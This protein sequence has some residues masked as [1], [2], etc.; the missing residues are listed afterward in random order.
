M[1][2]TDF[3]LIRPRYE[4]H[5]ESLLE[6]TADMHAAVGTTS[7]GLKEKLIAL[8]TGQDKIKK[9]GFQIPDPMQNSSRVVPK[10]LT[11][12]M[13]FYEE[14]I[15]NLF[16]NFYPAHC[17]LPEQFIH[18]TCTGY[19]FPSPAQK[20]ISKRG[21][22]Q[23]FVT[24]VYHMGC[25]A[26]IP[27]MRIAAGSLATEVSTVDIIHTEMCSLHFHPFK[28]T[29]EQLIIQSLF[30]DGFIKYSLQ[31]EETKNGLH[32]LALLEETL[33]D[34]L[35]CMQWRLED[36]CFAMT[37]SKKVPL[38]ITQSLESFFSRLVDKAKLDIQAMRSNA[39]FAIHPGGTKIFHYVKE[40]L[41]LEEWQV[42]HSLWV[43]QH[44]GNMSSAT[45][46]HI[47]EKMLHD[48][49][50]GA[51]VVSFAYGPGLTIA[52]ALLKKL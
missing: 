19:V 35:T 27:A 8:G 44:Y 2:L 52:G 10:G 32:C 29:T 41:G 20:L 5:Q 50:S 48:V 22:K 36:V 17:A 25:Y 37:L 34:S 4:M 49:P 12:R 47:W 6:W 9:R 1:I 23:S 33:P 46:P 26:S 16:E 51:Y 45:L 13:H 24:H 39:Y 11:E 42:A 14:E 18:V 31:R 7:S 43:L 38:H 21:A 28:Q 3:V 15:S 40:V 30:A